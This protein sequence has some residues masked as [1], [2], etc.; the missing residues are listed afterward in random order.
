MSK[1]MRASKRLEGL[2]QG[3]SHASLSKAWKG[4][5]LPSPVGL[6]DAPHQPVWKWGGAGSLLIEP[7][8]DPS[9]L[10]PLLGTLQP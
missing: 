4:V 8:S 9:S 10:S 1:E 2:W 6:Y 3:Q 5:S 7:A